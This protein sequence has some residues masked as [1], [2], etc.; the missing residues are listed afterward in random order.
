MNYNDL[1]NKIKSKE[2]FSFV[3]WG[4]GELGW[5]FKDDMMINLFLRRKDETTKE[6]LYHVSDLLKTSL[7]KSRELNN[8]YNGVQNMG[9]K[10]YTKQ[11]DEMFNGINTFDSSIIHKA[12]MKLGIND[13]FNALKGRHVIM[14][15][16]NYLS[17]LNSY[18]DS[19]V[20]TPEKYV[21]R[22]REEINEQIN[23]LIKKDSVVLYSCSAAANLC[24]VDNHNENITQIDTGSIFDPF[25]G[26]L[27]RSYH[28]TKEMKQIINKFKSNE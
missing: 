1:I 5:L 2:N 10:M 6:N 7:N 16:R 28:K 27:T 12:S 14:V 4:D 13:F 19:H 22:Q 20:V 9:Y 18:Y 24:A 25:C 8:F 26:H 11:V 3:R 15:G 17:G 21:W 23:K